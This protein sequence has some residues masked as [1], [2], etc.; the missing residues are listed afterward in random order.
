MSWIDAV[1]W[2][3][4]TALLILLFRKLTPQKNTSMPQKAAAW[5]AICATYVV[6]L[7]PGGI[8][9][10]VV[11]RCLIRIAAYCI[12]LS[13]Y[14]GIAL[15]PSLYMSG[16]AWIAFTCSDCIFLTPPLIVLRRDQAFYAENSIMTL[17]LGRVGKYIL[18][19]IIILI[20]SH[21]IRFDRIRRIRFE[22]II[23]L[24]SLLICENYLKY[25]LHGIADRYEADFD[26][27]FTVYP[28]LLQLL[29]IIVPIAFEHYISFRQDMENKRLT[30]TISERTY[31]Y[32]I[33][34]QQA[35]KDLQQMHHDMK[36]HLLALSSMIGEESSRASDYVDQLIGRMEPYELQANTGNVVLDGLLS[37]KS[38]LAKAKGIEFSA[39]IDFRPGSF[40]SDMDVCT[41]FGN[42]LDN[43]IEASSKA[44]DKS[45][46]FVLVKCTTRSEQLIISFTN[47]FEGKVTKNG[48]LPASTKLQPGHGIG[49]SS[50]KSTAAKYGG[51]VTYSVD[52]YHNFNLNVIIPVRKSE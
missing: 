25:S 34:Q 39:A 36:N 45:R 43:A 16:L 30:E 35:G 4:D 2:I 17:L 40:I 31:N 48:D 38:S 27:E 42:A 52:N 26:I 24:V 12:W 10:N 23:I 11:V 49:I 19:L 22:R 46:S 6:Y 33:A 20:F 37:E 9:G 13:L 1:N 15:V 28:V 5:L 51:I 7:P 3:I 18:T 41:I 47:Y 32:A 29:I 21:F 44:E 8:M 14:K 50:I